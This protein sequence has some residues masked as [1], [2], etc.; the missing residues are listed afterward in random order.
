MVHESIDCDMGDHR[1]GVD[2]V[3]QLPAIYV[4]TFSRI[5]VVSLTYPVV[6]RREEAYME[7]DPCT[8]HTETYATPLA[9]LHSNTN[10]SRASPFS[11]SDHQRS[12]CSRMPAGRV[13]GR[14]PK[15]WS[16]GDAS[17]LFRQAHASVLPGHYPTTSRVNHGLPLLALTGVFLF[18]TTTAR[19]SGG[20]LGWNCGYAFCSNVSGV[21]LLLMGDDMWC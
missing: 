4:C 16:P 1:V 9:D 15:A 12:G 13:G 11:A 21:I 18:G 17:N 19:S 6:C 5:P 10:E 8:Q 20:L 3:Q 7:M 2:V 14:T